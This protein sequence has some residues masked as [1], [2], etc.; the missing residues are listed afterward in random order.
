MNVRLNILMV[1]TPKTD[2]DR[3]NVYRGFAASPVSQRS[4]S[5]TA[6]CCRQLG[7]H[8][9]I[10]FTPVRLDLRLLRSTKRI[11]RSS[12]TSQQVLRWNRP[13]SHC[14]WS[15]GLDEELS[16][17]GEEG[18]MANSTNAITVG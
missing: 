13:K 14:P 18:N 1:R 4:D 6:W 2:F 9:K 17:R 11:V 12:S 8:R 16:L 15:N 5:S 10:E 7:L 3:I